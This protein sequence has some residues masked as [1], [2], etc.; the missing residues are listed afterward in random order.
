MRRTF[1]FRSI[2]TLKQFKL[3][4]CRLSIARTGKL[5]NSKSLRHPNFEC[6]SNSE[7]AKVWR[8]SSTQ[9]LG[10]D[11]CKLR[12]LE[13]SKVS[14]FTVPSLTPTQVHIHCHIPTCPNLGTR[15]LSNFNPSNLQTREASSSNT[16][17]GT[18]LAKV[19]DL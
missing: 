9:R 12:D 8:L 18:Q 10:L 2:R 16:L 17:A 6:R 15:D 13:R 5:S 14:I 11:N 19:C 7:A 4:S 3:P 1:Q